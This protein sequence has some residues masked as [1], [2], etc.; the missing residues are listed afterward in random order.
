M[1]SYLELGDMRSEE[2]LRCPST[3]DIEQGIAV[4]RDFQ[5]TS[6]RI[7]TTQEECVDLRQP[8]R[9]ASMSSTT[10]EVS[11]IAPPPKARL[12]SSNQ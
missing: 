6:Q 12:S 11:V 10:S 7:S 4:A 3:E 8:I 5:V 9:S 2:Q 1:H